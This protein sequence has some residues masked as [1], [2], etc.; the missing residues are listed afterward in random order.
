VNSGDAATPLIDVTRKARVSQ[1]MTT[2]SPGPPISAG[3]R[4]DSEDEFNS[5][6]LPSTPQYLPCLVQDF[7]LSK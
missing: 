7:S 1:T 4:V 3:V 5:N 2:D 6:I